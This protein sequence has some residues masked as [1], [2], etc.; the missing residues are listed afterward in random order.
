MLLKFIEDNL[1]RIVNESTDSIAPVLFVQEQNPDD[2]KPT[3][4]IILV[5]E[6]FSKSK[7]ERNKQIF[8]LGYGF[9][10]Q[11][12]NVTSIALVTEGWAKAF[13]K[14]V[15]LSKVNI[16]ISEYPDKKEII[17]ISELSL[18]GLGK[19]I[20][21]DIERDSLNNIVLGKRIEPDEIESSI[22]ECFYNGYGKTKTQ[23]IN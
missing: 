17:C 2:D 14:D 11:N 1:I 7:E 3:M 18:N 16:N 8:I 10:K 6:L 23:T 20:T 12:K 15:D 4:N 9:K 19:G 22:L 5:S 13:D 21:Y